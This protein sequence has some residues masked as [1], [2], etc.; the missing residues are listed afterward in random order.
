MQCGYQDAWRQR[1]GKILIGSVWRGKQ[2]IPR[3]SVHRAGCG[4]RSVAHAGACHLSTSLEIGITDQEKF[5]FCSKILLLYY[6]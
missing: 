2:N 6:L 4:V 3:Q 1:V 5:L